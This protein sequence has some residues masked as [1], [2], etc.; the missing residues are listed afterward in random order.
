MAVD[1]VVTMVDTLTFYA[2]WCADKLWL[3]DPL[4]WHIPE[5]HRDGVHADLQAAAA[6]RARIA[7]GQGE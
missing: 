3:S 1:A 5:D 2:P 7:L 6:L 4:R